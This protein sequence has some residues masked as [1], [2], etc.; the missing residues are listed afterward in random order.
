M[1]ISAAKDFGVTN[2]FLLL[3]KCVDVLPFL[4]YLMISVRNLKMLLEYFQTLKK[5]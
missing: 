2:L 4:S 5:F 1:E 3:E